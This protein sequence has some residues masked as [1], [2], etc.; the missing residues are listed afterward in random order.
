M[1]NNIVERNG[2]LYL[3]PNKI[4]GCPTCG[5]K[6]LDYVEV[7]RRSGGVE[8]VSISSSC[9]GCNT[10]KYIALARAFHYFDADGKPIHRER[11][12]YAAMAIENWNERPKQGVSRD[13]ENMM[14]KETL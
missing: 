13:T 14:D 10:V 8:R 11:E 4:K 2:V 6:D 12:K 3:N 5:N 9:H 7:R 1:S